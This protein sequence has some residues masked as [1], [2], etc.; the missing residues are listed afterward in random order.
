M[1]RLLLLV[2]FTLAASACGGTAGTVDTAVEPA[3]ESV[4]DGRAALAAAQGSPHVLWFWGA[5]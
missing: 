5:H 1:H 2:A 4:P 3:A